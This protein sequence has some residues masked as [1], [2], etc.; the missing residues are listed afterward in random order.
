MTKVHVVTSRFPPTAGGLERWT[1]DLVTALSRAGLMPVVY[2]CEEHTVAQSHCISPF[3]IVDMIPLLAPWEAPLTESRWEG[4]RL[5]QERS[6][7]RFACVKAEVAKRLSPGS[8]IILSNFLTTVGF[9]GHLVAEALELPHVPIIAGT[10]FN[11]GFHSGVDRQVILEICRSARIVVGK[12]LEQIRVIRRCLPD[13][14]Y[15]IIETSVEQPSRHWCKPTGKEIVIFSDG[16]FS[17]KKGTGVLIDAFV[18]LRARGVAARLVICGSDQAGQEDYWMARRLLFETESCLSACFPGYLDRSEI[19]D[20]ICE[21]DIYASATLGEGA[22]AARV[23]AL[24]LGVPMVTTACGELADDPKAQHIRL[25]PTCDA[26]AF[27]DAVFALATDLL[28]GRVTINEDVVDGF[29][30]RFDPQK[31]WAAWV[32][33]VRRITSNE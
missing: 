14:R 16:G 27:H 3:E 29:R 9:T 11:R 28:E 25:V 30:C 7:L 31:E 32:S 33:L 23:L 4:R 21:S 1:Q 2:V 24:C 5:E 26:A 20:Q 8:N 17:F 6:R 19:V 18:A 13:T 22:S 12:S 15:E 10:D